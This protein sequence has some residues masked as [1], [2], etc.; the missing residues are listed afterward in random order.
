MDR[1][2]K[3]KKRYNLLPFKNIYCYHDLTPKDF[4]DNTLY[5]SPHIRNIKLNIQKTKTFVIDYLTYRE[6]KL[7]SSFKQINIDENNV[8]EKYDVI[9]FEIV[10][11]NDIQIIQYT[12]LTLGYYIPKRNI[13]IASDWIYNDDCLEFF[14]LFY[15]K[16]LFTINSILNRK[17]FS[18]QKM[19]SIYFLSHSLSFFITSD[20]VKESENIVK[21]GNK[22]NN[23]KEISESINKYFKNEPVLFVRPCPKNPRHGI[24]ESIEVLNNIDVIHNTLNELREKMKQVNEK[25]NVVIQPKVNAISSFVISDK[26]I[27]FGESND[28]VTAGGNINFTIPYKCK[29]I[30]DI[31]K[32]VANDNDCYEAE[33]VINKHEQI[34]LTQ[35]RKTPKHKNIS[36]VK[37]PNTFVGFVNK[38]GKRFS[39]YDEIIFIANNKNIEKLEEKKN[40]DILCV[41]F[42]GN[43]LSHAAAWCRLNNYS[44]I[45]VPYDM[46]KRFLELQSKNYYINEINGNIIISK[47]RNINNKVRKRRNKK[48]WYENDFFKGI[49]I[50]L[51]YTK[52]MNDRHYLWFTYI[53]FQYY[54]TRTMVSSDY[55]LL[56][57]FFV[58]TVIKSLLTLCIGESRHAREKSKVPIY[59]LHEYLTLLEKIIDRN[60]LE[61]N[62]FSSTR[63]NKLYNYI[64]SKK[65]DLNFAKQIF[66]KLYEIFDDIKYEWNENY[67]G[68]LWKQICFYAIVMIDN[69]I[70]KR[71]KHI[72]ENTNILLNRM[73]NNG[74]LYNKLIKRDFLDI[75]YILTDKQKYLTINVIKLLNKNFLLLKELKNL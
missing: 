20:N 60:E 62:F 70:N 73:H 37:I 26:Y 49:N 34:F 28:G 22:H 38:N 46:T 69:I 67:G 27:V 19:E 53:P 42:G 15:T 6:K 43:I 11:T 57:G 13:L 74:W 52:F 71:L 50:A 44:Y 51:N 23:I 64:F 72:L 17:I 65:I 39:D 41:H 66:T 25:F 18:S 4:E 45:A 16:I 3:F 31:Y 9:E 68:N 35:I 58:G 14:D 47:N 33:G 63:R 8:N 75:I 1:L 29:T 21:F 30:I 12:K 55:A 5:I 7:P 40:K 10:C 24:L 32:Y 54:I 61:K 59:A 48:I 36:N 2:E 56:S